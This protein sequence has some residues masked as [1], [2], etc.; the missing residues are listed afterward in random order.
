[1]RIEQLDDYMK[2]MDIVFTIA[3]FAKV[4]FED[5]FGT[6][7]V[8]DTMIHNY[9]LD[10]NFVV[11]PTGVTQKLKKIAGAYVKDP[12]PGLYSNVMSFDLTS[13]YPHLIMQYNISPEMLMGQFEPIA[14][15]F[16]VDKILRGDMKQHKQYMLD[17][18]VTVSGKGTIFSKREIG[19][20]PKL[21]KELF[22]QRKA[23][24]DKMLVAEG[25]LQLI[26]AEIARR[27]IR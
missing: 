20:L 11:P 19:F 24:K 25:Q 23:N 15:Q 27:G 13:L 6:I 4:N 21:M 26:K 18:N 10:R 5:T 12:K 16:S 17:N 2:L 22:V 3:H 8:W 7:K 14:D 9:L 1:L